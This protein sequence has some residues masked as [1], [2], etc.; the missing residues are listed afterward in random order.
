MTLTAG[1]LL[2]RAVLTSVPALLAMACNP[3]MIL[4]A[5]P[6]KMC[7][8]ANIDV[9]WDTNTTNPRLTFD[10]DVTPPESGAV[11]AMG[12]RTVH[13]CDPTRIV[14]TG[15]DRDRE[16]LTETV[17][18]ESA[19]SMVVQMQLAFQSSCAGSSFV[20]WIAESL[21]PSDF[22]RDMTVSEVRHVSGPEVYLRHNSGAQTLVDGVS[23]FFAGDDPSGVWHARPTLGQGECSGEVTPIPGSPPP[24]LIVTMRCPDRI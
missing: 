18:I 4:Q 1:R 21:P 3:R 13:V 17:R 5:Q 15:N 12:S 23:T 20:E 11:A 8:C 16:P 19:A 7:R 10:P 22:V 24:V 6:T 9:T 2:S 14:L